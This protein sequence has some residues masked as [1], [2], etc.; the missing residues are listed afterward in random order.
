MAAPHP[1]PHSDE[2][3]SG[4]D[5]PEAPR[6]GAHGLGPHVVGQ[7]VVV[8]RMLPERGP[9]GG[10]AFTD[11][12]GTC[13]AWGDGACVVQPE[14][15]E[16]VSI[17]IDRIVSGK[18]VPPRPSVRHRVTPRE[19]ESHVAALWELETEPL[20]G[21]LLRTDPAPVGRL[22]RR[23]NSCLA[24]GDPGIPLDE[25]EPAIRAFY[26]ARERPAWVH[27]EAGSDVE[28]AFRERGWEP[29]ADGD[30]H[31]QLG[32]VVRARRTVDVRPLPEGVTPRLSAVSRH[33]AASYARGGDEVARGAASLDGD[34]LGLHSL[35]VAPTWRRR[36]LALHV[37]D[38][39]L[40]WGAEQGASTVWLHVETD[41]EPALALY[42]ALGLVTHHTA[43]YL[44]A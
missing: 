25:A 6:P 41:N 29:L 22:R 14:R 24:M 32:S 37:L 40:E 33:A 4:T 16:P 9:T 3:A 7:R 10:P 30:A 12:L 38:Q 20:G 21:W 28:R 26:A 13:V 18:P 34:W 15:G 23:A 35:H 11:V 36:G 17:P 43:R 1:D 31:F 2:P 8:R 42:G 27:V 5:A 44:G 39:L 19:A